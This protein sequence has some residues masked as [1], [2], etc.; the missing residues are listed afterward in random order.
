[1]VL[2][3][4]IQ[5]IFVGTFAGLALIGALAGCNNVPKIY[6]IER[7]IKE[8]RIEENRWYSCKKTFLTKDIESNKTHLRGDNYVE[9]NYPLSGP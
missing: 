1:M 8:C 3:K 6:T 9:H 4:K 7:I 5:D 2:K